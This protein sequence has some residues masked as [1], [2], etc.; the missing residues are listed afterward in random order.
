METKTINT[1]ST[2]VINEVSDEVANEVVNKGL[3]PMTIISIRVV[4]KTEKNNLTANTVFIMFK[5]SYE[6]FTFNQNNGL[7]EKTQTKQM[8]KSVGILGAILADVNDDMAI[9]M[10]TPIAAIIEKE[11]LS[12]M[13]KMQMLLTNLLVGS[14]FMIRSEEH[15]AGEIINGIALSRDQMFTYIEQVLFSNRAKKFIQNKVDALF[16]C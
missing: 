16:A 4:E 15:I 2:E 8:S 13:Q 6:T 3:K 11:G 12:D 5:E 10:S 14:K 9:L 7:F 1:M